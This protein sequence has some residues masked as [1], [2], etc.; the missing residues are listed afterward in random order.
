MKFVVKSMTVGL[1]M[2]LV[3]ACGETSSPPPV[4]FRIRSR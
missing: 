1:L 3:G 2:L 4:E